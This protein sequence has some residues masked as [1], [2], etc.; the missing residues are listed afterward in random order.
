[1][2]NIQNVKDVISC[3]MASCVLQALIGRE[4]EACNRT[5][6]GIQLKFTNSQLL[7]A[8][9]IKGMMNRKELFFVLSPEDDD[10]DI[11]QCGWGKLVKI[12]IDGSDNALKLLFDSGLFISALP[13][14]L[15]ETICMRWFA[16]FNNDQG[17]DVIF[18]EQNGLFHFANYRPG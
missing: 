14:K 18:G 7:L 1:M 11:S 17:A 10:Y 2:E 15:S 4:F 6:Y 12:G 3:E 13:L 5:Q 9:S 16:F 8:C